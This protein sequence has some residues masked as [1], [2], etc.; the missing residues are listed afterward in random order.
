MIPAVVEIG[1]VKA[2]RDN[3]LHAAAELLAMIEGQ[4]SR[5]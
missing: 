2:V 5:R 1:L 4:G 3:P